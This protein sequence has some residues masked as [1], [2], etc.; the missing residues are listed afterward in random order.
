MSGRIGRI[1][2]I[3]MSGEHGRGRAGAG[4]IDLGRRRKA[5]NAPPT[6]ENPMGMSFKRN[7]SIGK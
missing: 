3:V 5:G 2:G 4:I 6:D 1:Q 7:L